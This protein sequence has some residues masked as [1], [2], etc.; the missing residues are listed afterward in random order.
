MA[1][2]HPFPFDPTY[3]YDAV[4]LRVV[5]P[6]G[7]GVG[8]EPADLEAFWRGTYEAA[9]RV[10]AE[11][12]VREVACSVAGYR[13]A[14]VGFVGWDA[15]RGTRRLGGWMLWP[16]VE[17][18]VV[19]VVWTH[20]YGGRSEPPGEVFGLDDG[21]VPVAYWV[22]CLRGFD[23]SA[24]G[25]LPSSAGWHVLHGIGSRETYVHRGNAADVWASASALLEVFPGVRDRLLYW[26]G[27][28]GGGIGALGVPWDERFAA[29]FWDLPSFGHHPI[30]LGC[31]CV[32]SG[33]AVRMYHGRH[34]EV[35]GVLRY[36]DAALTAGYMMRPTMVG[37][38]LFDPAVPPPGQFAVFNGLRRGGCERE[39]FVR[40][41]GH[42]AE[43]EALGGSD[44][45]P[46]ACVWLRGV[47]GLG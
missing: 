25:D 16:E 17:E 34:P 5:E 37:A 39:L 13:L 43:G 24:A 10:E 3:G 42:Y 19:G 30:R 22:P 1:E 28:F 31:E 46:A 4:G 7:D 11:P 45:V 35:V 18:P 47:L 14:E 36:F 41:Y 6:P 8:G 32:G 23:R 29:A 12:V 33:E 40:R 27:S 44:P 20:G 38:A 26:G 15:E 9:L 2:K 21:G